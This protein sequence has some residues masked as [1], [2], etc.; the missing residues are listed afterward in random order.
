MI[1]TDETSRQAREQ[2][3]LDIAAGLVLDG[4][5]TIA[6]PSRCLGMG[7]RGTDL[8]WGGCTVIDGPFQLRNVT[9][10]NYTRIGMGC[11]VFGAVPK[12]GLAVSPW[13]VEDRL[14]ATTI[15]ADCWIGPG[16]LIRAGVTIGDCC[17]V[18]AGT[19]VSRDLPPFSVVRGR[20]MR[21]IRQRFPENIMECV[22]SLRW[23][24]YDWRE[25]KLDWSRTARTL[26]SMDEKI[27]KGFTRR[28]TAWRYESDG[29][30]QLRLSR[31]EAV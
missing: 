15:G 19:L 7:C 6:T 9:I 12:R 25:E 5:G 17:I 20:P 31:V 8:S 28:F 4:A 11:T 2:L 26:D 21:V 29:T 1:F 27:A 16:V 30:A 14:P 24:D 3:G 18:E 10:G 23:F 13:G 22:T